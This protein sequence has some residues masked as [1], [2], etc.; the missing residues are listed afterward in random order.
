[1]LNF[2]KDIK[3]LENEVNERF[4]IK[5]NYKYAED[6]LDRVSARCP[7]DIPKV[8]IAKVL[9][10]FFEVFRSGL[11]FREEFSIS[12]LITGKKLYYCFGLKD[13]KCMIMPDESIKFTIE[14]YVEDIFK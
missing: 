5:I 8:E 10:L 2:K 7:D 13:V 4:P 12:R 14:C 3:E 6:L 1:M 9:K 11:L